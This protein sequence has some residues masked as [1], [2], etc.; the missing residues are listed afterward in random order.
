MFLVVQE[1]AW[2]DHPPFPRAASSPRAMHA[3]A[4]DD[5][6]DSEPANDGHTATPG[7]VTGWHGARLLG[8][9]SSLKGLSE[10]DH[11]FKG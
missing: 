3:I 7:S 6:D 2:M 5:H 10:G 11:S 4:Y 9:A 1:G 8:K